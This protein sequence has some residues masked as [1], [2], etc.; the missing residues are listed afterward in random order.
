V[1]FVDDQLNVWCFGPG[2]GEFVVVHVPPDGWLAID[3][4]S[5][6]GQNYPVAFFD[7]LRRQPT[8]ILMTHPHLDHARGVR[9]LVE[10]HTSPS[11]AE[12]PMLGV[13]TPPGPAKPVGY[14]AKHESRCVLDA[15][16]AIVTRWKQR[17]AC[18]WRPSAGKSHA[19][20]AGTM[21]VL[22]P[23]EALLKKRRPPSF[24]VNQLSSALAIEWEGQRLILGSDLVEEPGRGWSEVLNTTPNAREHLMLKVAHH[25]SKAAQHVPLLAR[26]KGEKEALYIATPFASQDL[27]R[28][29]KS[30]GVAVLH[31]HADKLLLTGLPQA[32][33]NQHG[34]PRQWPLRKLAKM[35]KFPASTQPADGYPDCWI[36]VSVATSGKAKTSFGPGSVIVH[37]D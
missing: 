17:P 23:P 1:K 25:G 8:H 19:L 28:F 12:W 6:K 9:E 30:E 18:E 31:Q 14:Q 35:R 33:D 7:D 26:R 5:A 34:A 10:R 32:F 24:D 37:R 29:T 21:H 3:G 27:P 16:S 4:C 20:G 15:L 22:S 11:S 2:V 13:I 36:H